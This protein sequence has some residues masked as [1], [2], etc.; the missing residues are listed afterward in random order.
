MDGIGVDYY[1]KVDNGRRFLYMKIRDVNCD[2]VQCSNIFTEIGES[3]VK[4]SYENICI[5]LC[6]MTV[7]SSMVFGVCINIISTAKKNNKKIKFRFNADAMETAIL[8][9]FN[10]LVEIEQGC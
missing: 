1:F 7:V 6:S 9:S 5:D 10:E 2:M 4:S 8:N 3:L